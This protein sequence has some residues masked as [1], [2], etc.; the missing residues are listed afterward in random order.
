MIGW[1]GASIGVSRQSEEESNAFDFHVTY[2][3]GNYWLY[4]PHSQSSLYF[5]LQKG[6]LYILIADDVINMGQLDF[7]VQRFNC[8]HHETKG[9]RLQMEDI[10]LLKHELGFSNRLS[11]SLYAVFDGHGGIDCVSYVSEF[12][13]SSLRNQVMQ[14]QPFDSQ[15][16]LYTYI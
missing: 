9:T 16:N 6:E 8:G 3:C 13:L 10:S 5:R 2:Q 7:L 15:T 12:I 4:P 11:V 1:G 14:A